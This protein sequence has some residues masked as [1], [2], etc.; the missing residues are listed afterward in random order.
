MRAKI[1]LKNRASFSH[2]GF[3]IIKGQPQIIT[4]PSDINYLKSVSCLR[5]TILE[6]PKTKQKA[7]AD[8]EKK[9]EEILEA[10]PIGESEGLTDS[11]EGSEEE[12]DGA[13]FTF[14]E[15]KKNNTKPELVKIAKEM[16]VFLEGSE[17][18]DTMVNAILDAQ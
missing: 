17:N 5:V 16:G 7:L 13:I 14:K 15:L 3:K 6:A 1:E 10:D 12:D 9:S 8:D 11:D 18:K 2:R 4:N